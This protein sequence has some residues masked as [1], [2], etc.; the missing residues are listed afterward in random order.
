M[1]SWHK[2]SVNTV[3]GDVRPAT[4]APPRPLLLLDVDGVISLFG[5]PRS[6]PPPGR[7]V[8]VEGIPH[9]VSEQAGE[10]LRALG[11]AFRLAWCTG[12]DEKADEVLPRTLGLPSG[13]PSISL[14][15]IRAPAGAHWK[16]A[17]IDAFAGPSTPLAWV[18]DGLDERCERWRLKRPG[19]TLL[20]R[21][22][23]AVGLTLAHAE[24]LLA[25]ASSVF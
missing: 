1:A 12:W 16:L 9:L 25:W 3:P 23:P 21:T 19:A 7:W 17:A 14:E 13:L 4:E 10:A 11:P 15:S 5:F 18:D 2:G 24:R 22:D 20:L 6:S 8:L